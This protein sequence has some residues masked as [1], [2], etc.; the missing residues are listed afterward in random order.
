MTNI[1]PYSTAFHG[2]ALD[3]RS[4]GVSAR[5]DGAGRTGAVNQTPD[6]VGARDNVVIQAGAQVTASAMVGITF[7]GGLR[8]ASSLLQ[9]ADAGLSRIDGKLN[10]MRAL[11]EVAATSPMDVLDRVIINEAFKELMGESGEIARKTEFNG[12]NPLA[13]VSQEI[14]LGNGEMPSISIRS[15]MMESFAPKLAG[16]DLLSQDNALKSIVEI[17]AAKETVA[18][19]REDIAFMQARIGGALMGGGGMAL[20]TIQGFGDHVDVGAEHASA[21]SQEVVLEALRPNDQLK[22][23]GAPASNLVPSESPEDTDSDVT[24]T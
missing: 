8:E 17:D 1:L 18:N 22:T 9:L 10:E 21:I 6:A 3:E 13:G 14:D 24:P 19:V 5:V 4:G 15:M 16:D 11:A 12:K 20:E 2:K 7:A 23:A